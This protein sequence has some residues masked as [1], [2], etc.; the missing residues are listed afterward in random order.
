[1]PGSGQSQKGESDYAG[2]CLGWHP[3]HFLGVYPQASYL[4]LVP[5]FPHL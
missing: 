3:G 2:S 5:Q 1:M 4:T